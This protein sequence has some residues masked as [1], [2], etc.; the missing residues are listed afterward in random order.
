MTYIVQIE[1]DPF[2]REVVSDAVRSL[3]ADCRVQHFSTGIEVMRWISSV[4][5]TSLNLDSCPKLIFLDLS[6]PGVDG[7]DLLKAFKS[8]PRLVSSPVIVLTGSN[9]THDYLKCMET[10]C[11]GYILK[12]DDFVFVERVKQ[13]TQFWLEFSTSRLL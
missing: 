2:D 7:N 12:D 3:K 6:I 5:A 8:H 10:G 13:I 1:D 9:S 11:N 4:P